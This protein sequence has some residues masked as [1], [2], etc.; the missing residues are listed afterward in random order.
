MSDEYVDPDE[1][2][3]WVQPLSGTQEYTE[4][5]R[6]YVTT[7]ICIAKVHWYTKTNE[8]VAAVIHKPFRKINSAGVGWSRWQLTRR[9]FHGNVVFG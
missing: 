7:M 5:L 4:D 3:V 9:I 1:I 2:T 6:Q 8:P